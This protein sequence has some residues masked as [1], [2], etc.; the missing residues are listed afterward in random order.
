VPS[1]SHSHAQGGSRSNSRRAS[2]SSVHS[3]G[4]KELPGSSTAIAASPDAPVF[5]SGT[6]HRSDEDAKLIYQLQSEVAALK[7]AST[8]HILVTSDDIAHLDLEIERQYNKEL[9]G[10]ISV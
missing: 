10:Q 8:S 5:A 2:T 4:E 3:T 9:E 1:H 6:R 7:S